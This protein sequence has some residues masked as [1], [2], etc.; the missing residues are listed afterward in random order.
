MKPK[1]H[2]AFAI[3]IWNDVGDSIVKHLAS[4][5]NFEGACAC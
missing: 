2:F 1:R 3:D 4:V 5:D